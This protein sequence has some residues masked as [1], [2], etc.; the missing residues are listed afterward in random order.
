M[1]RPSA[2]A[3]ADKQLDDIQDKD[4]GLQATASLNKSESSCFWRL[5]HVKVSGPVCLLL[6]ALGVYTGTLLK[7]TDVLPV[8]SS[9]VSFSPAT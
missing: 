2:A 4:H 8:P 1:L 5:R 9:E 3:P 7:A 6:V